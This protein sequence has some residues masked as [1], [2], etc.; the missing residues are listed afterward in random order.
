MKKKL[1]LVLRAQLMRR[2]PTQ[3]QLETGRINL[4]NIVFMFLLP[5]VKFW[6]I[7]PVLFFFKHIFLFCIF[8]CDSFKPQAFHLNPKHARKLFKIFHTPKFSCVVCPSRRMIT[9]RCA[10]LV[11]PKAPPLATLWCHRRS[12]LQ[13]CRLLLF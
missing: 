3:L 4:L 9:Q 6:N 13:L 8:D 11:A 10:L 1:V 7:L 2:D 12:L 5:S